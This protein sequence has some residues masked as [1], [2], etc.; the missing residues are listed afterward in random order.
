MYLVPRGELAGDRHFPSTVRGRARGADAGARDDGSAPA[1]PSGRNAPPRWPWWL[2]RCG[3]S[4]R[5]RVPAAGTAGCSGSSR[6]GR[7][8]S[9]WRRARVAGA[10]R[11]RLQRE[12]ARL[13]GGHRSRSRAG[14]HAATRRVR[15]LRSKMK[16]RGIDLLYVPIPAIEEVYPENFLDA[17]PA[18]LTVQ[19]AMRRFMLSL[20]E[21]DVEVVDLLRPFQAARDA[22]IASG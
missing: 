7:S 16:R 20:L 13:P 8:G 4:W 22:A 6:R 21:R 3:Q 2:A 1:R 17:A 11:L 19:P 18:D 14:R 9:R 5:S 10:Q 12:R 15:R